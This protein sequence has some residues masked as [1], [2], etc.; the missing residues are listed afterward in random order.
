M[1]GQDVQGRAMISKSEWYW[2]GI[3]A[4]VIVLV[5][6]MPY[7][8]AYLTAPDGLKFAVA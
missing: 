7:A 2:V 5:A 6:T 1:V 8:T 4:L 3:W